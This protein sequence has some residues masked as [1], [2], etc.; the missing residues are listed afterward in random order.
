M[1]LNEVKAYLRVDGNSE[2]AVITTIMEAAVAAAERSLNYALV[3]ATYQESVTLEEDT[4]EL[5][6]SWGPV[7]TTD[8]GTVVASKWGIIKGDFTKGDHT[9]TYTVTPHPVKPNVKLAILR[10]IADAFDNRNDPMDLRTTL[11]R[12][13]ASELLLLQEEVNVFRNG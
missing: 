8:M 2:D 6:L 11:N 5:I 12:A 3:A 4:K 13:K 1:T 9:V 10:I 7:G